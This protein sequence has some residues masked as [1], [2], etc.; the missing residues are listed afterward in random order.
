MKINQVGQI[1]FYKMENS[2]KELRE[3]NNLLRENLNNFLF[4]VEA[5]EETTKDFFKTIERLINNEIELEK[6]CNQ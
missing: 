5:D 2:F 4:L 6:F 1:K 3:E